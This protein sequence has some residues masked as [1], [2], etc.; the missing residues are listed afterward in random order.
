[1][2]ETRPARLIDPVYGMEVDVDRA[3]QGGLPLEREGRTFGFCGRGCRGAFLQEPARHVA[4]AEAAAAATAAIPPELASRSSMRVQRRRYESCSCCLSYVYPEVKAQL[5]AERA[6]Q[7]APPVSRASARSRRRRYRRDCSCCSA[8]G[9]E[10]WRCTERQEETAFMALEDTARDPSAPWMA[11][12]SRHASVGAARQRRGP[13]GERADP[14]D[15]ASH[16]ATVAGTR[17]RPRSRSKPAGVHWCSHPP[18]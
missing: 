7:A 17:R 15:L 9:G 16:L 8:D 6:T 4:H 12:S 2:T 14:T 5:D 13:D 11:R 1:M 18:R 10:P 3:E